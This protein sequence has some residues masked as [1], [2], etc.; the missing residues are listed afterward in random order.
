MSTAKPAADATKAPAREGTKPAKANAAS[1]TGARAEAAAKPAK[2]RTVNTAP[3][4]DAKKPA[5]PRHD[6]SRL[7]QILIADREQKA[8]LSASRRVEVMLRPSPRSRPRSS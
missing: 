4:K 3:K 8:T 5:A 2:K 6:A 7:A 1:R